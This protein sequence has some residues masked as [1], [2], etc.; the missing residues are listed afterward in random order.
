MFNIHDIATQY[1][2]YAMM[3]AFSLALIESLPFIGSLVPGMLTMPAIGWLMASHQVP[4]ITTFILIIIG[5][6]IGDYIGYYMGYFCRSNAYQ[7]AIEYHKVHWLQAGESFVKKHGPMSVVIGRFFGPFRSSIPLFAGIFDMHIT[8]FSLAAL[9]SVIL[10]AIIHLAPGAI[11]VWLDFDILQHSKVLF[12]YAALSM[13][14]L[15]L[16][17]AG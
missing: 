6:M 2:E 3:I 13:V 1:P 15:L 14:A 5:A 12:D 4:P 11:I 10:W 16:F 8:P 7:K 9:P 17:I